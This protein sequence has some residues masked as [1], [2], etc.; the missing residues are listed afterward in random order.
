MLILMRRAGESIRIGDDITVKIV[1]F[2]RNRVR[3]GVNAPREV[4]V[5]RE[6][7]A[8]KKRLALEPP[9]KRLAATA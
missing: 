9:P 4:R 3:V 1:S 2:E 5:D 7:V 8:E 6:E